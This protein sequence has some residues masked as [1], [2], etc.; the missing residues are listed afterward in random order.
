MR[1]PDESFPAS[2]FIL[3][4]PKWHRGVLGI[5]ASRVVDRTGR[6]SLILT[7]AEDGQAHGSGRSVA[8]FHLLDALTAI[9]ALTGPLPEPLFS[10]FGGHAYAVGFSL[11]SE[12]LPILRERMAAHTATALTLETLTPPLGCDAALNLDNLNPAFMEWLNRCGPFGIG[13]P[14]PIFITTEAIVTAPVRI[15]QDRHVCLTVRQ[16]DSPQTGSVLGW[17]R[18][19]DWRRR[20]EELDLGPGA[21]ID[22]AYRL[23]EKAN[24]RFPGIDLELVDL[25]LASPAPGIG[26]AT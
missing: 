5:L 11:P 13:N 6:P 23:K 18:R 10:R 2:C 1:N 12:R 22:I 17:S 9:H 21:R 16:G 3:D 24:P 15:I 8:G 20:C 14:E 4:D 19:I 25:R 7:H 26:A